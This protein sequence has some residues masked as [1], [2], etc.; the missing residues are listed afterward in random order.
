[1]FPGVSFAAG[2]PPHRMW[3]STVWGASVGRRWALPGLV[4]IQ[5]AVEN[6]HRKSGFTQLQMLVMFNSFLY[7]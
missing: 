3:P 5:K 4:N 7:V 6:G 1:M 2:D